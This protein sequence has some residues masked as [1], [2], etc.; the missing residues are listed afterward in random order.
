MV[1]G[2]RVYPIFRH[3]TLLHGTIVTGLY[4]LGKS[5][6][7]DAMY[8]DRIG[9]ALRC[10]NKASEIAKKMSNPPA[11]VVMI[12]RQLVRAQKMAL[13]WKEE[14]RLCQESPLLRRICELME[15]ESLNSQTSVSTSAPPISPPDDEQGPR[16]DWVCCIA[17]RGIPL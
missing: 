17:L 12:H 10:L 15:R 7:A 14:D 8:K 3:L 9:Q 6:V 11:P 16:E 2:I 13:L 4:L 5:L 1:R